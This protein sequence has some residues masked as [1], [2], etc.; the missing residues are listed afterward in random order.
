MAL[1][2][3]AAASMLALRGLAAQPPSSPPRESPGSGLR[4]PSPTELEESPFRLES[5]G[6]SLN[7]PLRSTTQTGQVGQNTAVQVIGPG[8]TWLI[9][10]QTP[11]VTREQ[12]TPADAAKAMI[13]ETLKQDTF[14][15]PASKR[16][17]TRIEQLGRPTVVRVA[18]SPTP[19]ERFYLALP[20]PEKGRPRLVRGYTIFKPLP[21][22]FVV[23]E[24]IATEDV[25][26][27][28]RQAYE[29]SIATATFS[30]N[31]ELEAE[32]EL[33]V[34]TGIALLARQGPAE[35]ERAMHP[36]WRWYRLYRPAPGGAAAD[37]TELGYRG[38]R[39]WRGRRSDV[40]DGVGGSRGDDPPGFLVQIKARVLEREANDPAPRV[41]YDHLATVFLSEDRDEETWSVRTAIRPT[42]AAI[43]GAAP[44]KPRIATETGA[45][46]GRSMQ[47]EM[48]VPG[49]MP[50]RIEPEVRGEGYLSQFEV[51]LLPRLLVLSQVEAEVGFYAYRSEAETI[52][53]RRDLISRD[54]AAAGVWTVSTRFRENDPPQV[55]R[56]RDD[57][58]LLRTE[59]ADG[60]VWEPT[61]PDELAKLWRSKQLPT[62]E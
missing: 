32:R 4:D 23:F 12:A 35:Y 15:D 25:F 50:R 57:G 22:R 61:D 60:S 29:T 10:I 1:A 43:P 38:V 26:A 37:A 53:L 16:Q 18:G 41:V 45:R 2:A 59:Q 62:D 46:R 34:R 30:N 58:S 51:F 21:D 11:R 19:A 5:V 28:A 54:P 7:L 3:C 14:T 47:V 13:A 20:A 9:N 42:G 33:A 8:A 6:L 48:A 31:A 40:G 17:V 44:P 24:L 55:S 49:Q 39:F 27:S 56:F 36:E 52:A